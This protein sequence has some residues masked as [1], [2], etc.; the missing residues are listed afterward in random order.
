[1]YKLLVVDDEP[2]VQVGIKS[3]LPWS[4]LNIEIT[5]V[6]SNGQAALEMIEKDKPDIVITDIKMPIMSG[7][8]LARTCLERY[9]HQS[10][11]FIVLTS[12]EDFHLA[13]EALSCHVSD[14]LVKLEL[15]PDVLQKSV[16]TIIT[17]LE[18]NKKETEVAEESFSIHP[19]HDKFFIRLLHN[20]F[21][22]REQFELQCKE[23]Q[24]NFT[25]AG[26][27]C[28][29][30]EI[31]E[32]HNLELPTEKQLQLF[33]SAFQ[34]AKNL[35]TKYHS[36][37]AM[38]LDLR[39]FALIFCYDA[40]ELSDGE[41]S[42]LGKESAVK[43]SLAETLQSVS[44]TLHNYY[45]VSLH[46]GIGTLVNDPL[47]ISESY[48]YSR[49]AFS[50][51]SVE[52]NAPLE[53]N[54]SCFFD[55]CH[56]VENDKKSFNFS[57][58]KE[59]LA[60]AYEE[61][62]SNLLNETL[63]EIITLFKANPGHYLQAMDCASNILYLSISLLPNGEETVSEIFADSSDRYRTL[64]KMTTMEQV[65]QWLTYFRDKLCVIFAERKKEVRKPIVA[66]VKYYIKQHVNDHLSLNEVAAVFG[67]SPNYLS[68]LFKKYNDMGY[69]EYVTQCKIDEARRLL[70]SGNYKVY[71]V[72]ET[73]GFESA[74]YFS[75]VFKKVVGIP[76]TDFMK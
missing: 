27:V 11:A 9:N 72:A 67:I 16:Q 71:E 25:H 39:H 64:Y 69:N 43:S 37:H 62:N 56:K 28:C 21:E 7:L 17:D 3:M 38:M 57:I 50:A 58:F 33:H 19:Y 22:N 35:F 30:C 20:L 34:M 8:E 52:E 63:T 13:K 60:K 29:Y 65:I 42:F 70:S 45:N 2:L 18:C 46:I 73:L 4:N 12:Y 32:N 74:F 6:A 61:L 24:L 44:T 40:N 31:S 1:M 26:Y 14:Y 54:I 5:N 47:A 41:N 75:K 10:P 49:D 23:L 76:P 48:Q 55:D 15:T 51:M 36:C 66:Q 68:Q 59:S 53:P